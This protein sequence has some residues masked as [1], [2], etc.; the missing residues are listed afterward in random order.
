M[1]KS[2]S[3]EDGKMCRPNLEDFTS[4]G[5]DEND[6]DSATLD[7]MKSASLHTETDFV[8]NSD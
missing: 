7:D 5:S 4:I 1:S 2:E 6:S 3:S 8:E